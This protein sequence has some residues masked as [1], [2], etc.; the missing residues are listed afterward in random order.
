LAYL[1]GGE[2]MK[3]RFFK[4]HSPF[5]VVAVMVIVFVLA[6]CAYAFLIKTFIEQTPD[7]IR[8]AG[9]LWRGEK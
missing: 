7:A 6:V 3:K 4:E 2:F 8:A 5:F 9:E 1:V